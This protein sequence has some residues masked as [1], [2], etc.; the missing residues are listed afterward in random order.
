MRVS[1]D[2][3]RAE[4]WLRTKLTAHPRWNL[5][6]WSQLTKLD[7]TAAEIET[8]LRQGRI[9]TVEKGIYCLPGYEATWQSRLYLHTLKTGGRASH[10]SAALLW[11]LEDPKHLRPGYAEVR[12]PATRRPEPRDRLKIR[13]SEFEL[14]NS[15]ETLVA[16][17]AEQRAKLATASGDL[18]SDP[19]FPFTLEHPE[20]TR[21]G[22]PC[23]PVCET[24]LDI[25]TTASRERFL[26][27]YAEATRMSVIGE[28]TL[29]AA[30]QPRLAHGRR[31]S[32]ILR[33]LLDEVGRHAPALSG[34]S[35]LAANALEENGLPRPLLEEVI[36]A[37]NGSRIGQVDL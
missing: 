12:V 27:C 10:L 14:P 17:A 25:A 3:E 35:Y 4:R 21:F 2:L 36:F 19:R 24:L 13:Y 11:G 32:A 29:I 18:G 23:T 31:G 8:A 28:P 26:H 37:S 16:P 20:G 15:F 33:G 30:A 5:L 9:E 1:A 22:I 7:H 6:T 34:W